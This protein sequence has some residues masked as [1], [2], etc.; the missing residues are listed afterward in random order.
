MKLRLPFDLTARP[1]VHVALIVA[2]LTLAAP[3]MQAQ[4]DSRS[5]EDSQPQE[6]D[7]VPAA[8][9]Q[10]QRGEASRY[11]QDLVIGSLARGD[12][13]AEGRR[14]AAEVLGSLMTGNRNARALS[15]ISSLARDEL[16]TA[17]EEVDPR[18]YRIG[19]GREEV[20]G[21]YSFLIRF[22]GRERGIAG[23]LYLRFEPGQAGDADGAGATAGAWLLDDL[24]LE[25]P[26]DL[27]EVGTEPIFNFPP[28]ERLF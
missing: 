16:F 25:E 8:L 21:A 4:E 23:E 10:P 5:Q 24:L 17:I 7:S 19:E 2:L 27:G 20:D 12:V 1:S 6:R 9:R 22:L 28:Y 14:F 11:P 26:R 13:P 18:R 3:D 15:G